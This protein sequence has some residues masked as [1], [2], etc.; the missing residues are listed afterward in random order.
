MNGMRAA[1]LVEAGQVELR[2]VAKP[3]VGPFDVLVAPR[4]V[5]IC[6]SDLHLYRHGKIGTSVVERPLILGH[7]PA[8][9]VVAVGDSVR[10]LKPGDRVVVEPGIACGGCAWC[11][12]GDYN[13]CPHVRF[14]GIPPSDGAM[15]ELVAVPARFVHRLPDAMSWAE[16]A[17][18][19][20]FAIGLQA[21]KSAGVR[22]GEAVVV[23][24]AGPIGLMILQAARIAGAATLISIDVAERPLALAARLGATATLDAR[25][26]NLIERVHDLTGGGADHAIEAVGARATVEN[27]L[28]IVRR[29]GT[30]TL[31]GIAAEPGIPLDTIRIVRTG[32]TIRSSFRYTHVHPT[33]IALA[34]AQRVD[35]NALVTHRYDLASVSEAFQEVSAG[36][37]GVVKA[38]VEL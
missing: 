22:T 15:A 7:E 29:G 11:Q 2:R 20:P 16:G 23:L 8:G 26:P 5:G 12:R 30:V 37:N 21:V 13:L 32:L 17:M 25:E 33:A 24:G 31:V 27:A 34:A 35:L 18:I 9:E 36:L 4:A 10:E 14:L 19:E 38:V 28:Q 3:D 6:G 1:V